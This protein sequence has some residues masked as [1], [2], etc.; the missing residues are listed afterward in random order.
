MILC[1]ITRLNIAF[2]LAG[3]DL[4]PALIDRINITAGMLRHLA[5]H[6]CA[7]ARLISDIQV[8]IHICNTKSVIL[9]IQP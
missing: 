5:D 7:L 1:Q 6:L 9:E 4:R 3:H 2:H 8:R